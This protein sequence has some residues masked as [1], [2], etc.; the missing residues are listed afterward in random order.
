MN[1]VPLTLSALISLAPVAALLAEAGVEEAQRPLSPIVLTVVAVLSVG[2]VWLRERET[3]LLGLLA[4]A[5]WSAGLIIA[6]AFVTPVYWCLHVYLPAKMAGSD[7]GEPFVLLTKESNPLRAH[8]LRELLVGAGI[9]LRVHGTEDA[10]GIGM[11]Q[12]IVTQR[13]KVPASQLAEAQEVLN[14]EPPESDTSPEL[15]ED[16]VLIEPPAD[17]TDLPPS[18]GPPEAASFGLVE[19]L[20]WLVIG[21][22]ALRLLGVF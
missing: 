13:F 11:G 1:R 9:D 5:T 19:V 7:D 22:V 6:G 20:I 21:G 12:F 3:R 10:A 17:V 8:M 16:E 2:H 14:S 15:T 4:K 18:Q